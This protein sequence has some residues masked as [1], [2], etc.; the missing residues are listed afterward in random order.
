MA[1]RTIA[2]ITTLLLLFLLAVPAFAAESGAAYTVTV[3][4]V[5]PDGTPI[6]E[7]DVYAYEAGS[8]YDVTAIAIDGYAFDSAEG[9]TSGILTADVTITLVYVPMETAGA[10]IPAVD[11]P[12]DDIPDED[13]PLSDDPSLSGYFT[14]TVCF[15]DANGNVIREAE[16]TQQRGASL[17]E[18]TAPALDSY[19]FVGAEGET[20]GILTE[21]VTVTLVYEPL[22][23]LADDAMPL[24]EAP[25]DNSPPTGELGTTAI[26]LTLAAFSAGAMVLLRRRSSL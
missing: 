8:L 4:Y 6:H 26:W 24:A 13:P 3:Q 25:T 1:K 22:T 11:P 9:E 21:D 19:G 15:R 16:T 20:E 2:S 7:P 12:Y 5:D 23:A 18:V 14:I 10:D 17:Y